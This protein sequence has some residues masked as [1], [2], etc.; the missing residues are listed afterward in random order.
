MT[1]RSIGLTSIILVILLGFGALVA[2]PAV[3]AGT[4]KPAPKTEAKQVAASRQALS[5]ADQAK[6]DVLK[7]L[8]K[9]IAETAK[10]IRE[11][12]K[13]AKAA[14]KDLAPFIADLK[15]AQKDATHRLVSRGLMLTQA[16]RTQLETMQ[17]SVRALEQQLKTQRKAKADKA[18]L[19]AIKA[20]IKTAVTARNA[21]LKTVRTAALAQYSA[22]LDT[23]IAEAGAKLAFMQALLIRLP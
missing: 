22:R 12:V 3:Y 1:R 7:G 23:L 8:Y 11:K 4:G 21:F 13:A 16:E 14:G 18:V 5:P 6:L 2:V 19:D 17:S 10:A 15:T 9:Q 20:Q